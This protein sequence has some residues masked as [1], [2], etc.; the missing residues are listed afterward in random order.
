MFCEDFLEIQKGPKVPDVRSSSRDLSSSRARRGPGGPSIPGAAQTGRSLYSRRR[1]DREDNEAAKYGRRGGNTA[2]SHWATSHSERQR[3]QNPHWQE[4]GH[5]VRSAHSQPLRHTCS[6][7][8]YQASE[9]QV[10]TQEAAKS[11]PTGHPDQQRG[12]GRRGESRHHLL[13]LPTGHSSLTINNKL[14]LFK[15]K[16][17]A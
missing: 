2:S 9:S 1:S 7:E 5:C 17:C 12:G 14:R 11:Q 6:P 10:L 8:G 4:T 3:Q 15:N 16:N 13:H